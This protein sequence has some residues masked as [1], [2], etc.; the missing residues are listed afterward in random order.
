MYSRVASPP[1]RP[2]ARAEVE[3]SAENVSRRRAPL[4]RSRCHR[5]VQ[6]AL[7]DRGVPRPRHRV[8]HPVSRLGGV[9]RQVGPGG[10]KTEAATGPI[11]LRRDG[12]ERPPAAA[13]SLASSASLAAL[14]TLAAATAQT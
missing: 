2:P 13:A 5:R 4:S 8:R 6:G 7:H 11:R 10:A 9:L 14:A 12:S 3:S 1:P